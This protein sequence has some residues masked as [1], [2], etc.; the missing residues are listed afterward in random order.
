MPNVSLCI[1]HFFLDLCEEKTVIRTFRHDNNLAQQ[2]M[3]AASALHRRKTS[4]QRGVSRR[5]PPK[6][7]AGPE[8]LKNFPRRFM[9]FFRF[10][11]LCLSITMDRKNLVGMR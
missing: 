5:K 9:G 6:T 3:S 1:N 11:F 8:R 10:V 4:P 7:A 2:P